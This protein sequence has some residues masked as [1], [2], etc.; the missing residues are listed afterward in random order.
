MLAH[1]QATPTGI[2]D[3][4]PNPSPGLACF[5]SFVLHMNERT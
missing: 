4:G 5:F 3:S 2:G 1:I